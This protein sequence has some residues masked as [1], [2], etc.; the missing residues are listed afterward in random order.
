MPTSEYLDIIEPN[1]LEKA[2]EILQSQDIEIELALSMFIHKVVEN[3][4]LPF[5]PIPTC[6]L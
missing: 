4:G 2:E 3:N 1:I 5:D 6:D